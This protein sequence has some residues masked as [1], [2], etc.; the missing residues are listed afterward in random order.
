MAWSQVK[1][2]AS[3]APAYNIAK[4]Q[5]EILPQCF[6]AITPEVAAKLFHHEP[7]KMRLH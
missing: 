2:Q 7:K 4:L 3:Y 6:H 1:G 5:N